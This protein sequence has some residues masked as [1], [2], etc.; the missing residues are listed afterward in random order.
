MNYQPL[1]IVELDALVVLEVFLQ[2]VRRFGGNFDR[3]SVLLYL[4]AREIQEISDIIEEE[5]LHDDGEHILVSDFFP[6]HL[7]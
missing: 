5:L 6:V 2:Q 4:L 3:S 7:K 1:F